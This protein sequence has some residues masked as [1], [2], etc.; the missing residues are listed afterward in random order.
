LVKLVPTSN[1]ALSASP[2]C[3]IALLRVAQHHHGKYQLFTVLEKKKET[4]KGWWQ[5]P[6]SAYCLAHPLAHVTHHYIFLH[7][8][9]P[10]QSQ[11]LSHS[12]IGFNPSSAP[13]PHALPDMAWLQHTS[14]FSP[15]PTCI[16]AN[17][18][19]RPS[20]ALPPTH[21][22]PFQKPCRRKSLFTSLTKHGSV[23]S[24]NQLSVATQDSRAERSKVRECVREEG[25]AGGGGEGVATGMVTSGPSPSLTLERKAEVDSSFSTPKDSNFGSHRVPSSTCPSLVPD[26]K[27][28]PNDQDTEA[29]SLQALATPHGR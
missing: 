13:W 16:T 26:S 25:E 17:T 7:R 22:P 1:F 28:G 29:M 6:H 5:P 11:S 21:L 19:P 12:L 2:D 24:P 20:A 3:S 14:S 8:R 27:T 23:S 4:D 10:S 9:V 15:P 18:C